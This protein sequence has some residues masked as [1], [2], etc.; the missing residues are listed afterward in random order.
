MTSGNIWGHLIWFTLPLLAGTV[1]QQLYNMVDTII[2]GHFVG[3]I[4]LGA[5]GS[6]G[7]LNFLFFSLCSGLASGIGI[8][9]AQYFGAG[10]HEKVKSSVAQAVYVTLAAG[11]LMSFIGCVFYE[12][13]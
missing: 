1:F 5:V 10:E 3:T 12:T 8:L 7:S 9:V 2:V 4:A 6:I 11:L 13:F